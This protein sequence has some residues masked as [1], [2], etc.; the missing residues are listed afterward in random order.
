MEKYNCIDLFRD[1]R[2]RANESGIEFPKYAG[3]RYHPPNKENQRWHLNIDDDWEDVTSKCIPIYMYD[4]KK[5]SNNQKHIESLDKISASPA[6]SLLQIV[7]FESK[8]NVRKVSGV[9][10][11]N[12]NQVAVE[13]KQN[14][15]MVSGVEDLTDSQANIW[16]DSLIVSPVAPLLNI[17]PKWEVEEN[18][19]DDGREDKISIVGTH[20]EGD[21]E[22]NSSESGDDEQLEVEVEQRM[23]LGAEIV[24]IDADRALVVN[25]MAKIL[26][27]GTLWTRNKD[28]KN[29]K[30][31]EKF[32]A[33]GF[34]ENMCP[35]LLQKF[36]FTLSRCRTCKH[37]GHNAATCG[38][39]RDEHGRL[40]TKRKRIPI[41]DR[42]PKPR[43]S[44]KNQKPAT[45]TPTPFTTAAA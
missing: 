35:P 4:L 9:E 2:A 45:L 42:V 19:W 16:A 34:K 18:E 30:G 5:P 7:T 44:P 8:M 10:D 15:R 21:R 25:K 12:G 22:N 39:P 43:G 29:Y 40:L 36:C 24:D 38:R 31:L 26:G 11:L 37:L 17:E 13:S 1:A 28:G 41:E 14:V 33:Y 32:Y 20:T 3:F 6:Q 23:Q 27:Q